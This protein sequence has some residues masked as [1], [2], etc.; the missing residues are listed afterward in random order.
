MLANA[1]SLAKYFNEK[2][3]KLSTGGTDNHILLIDLKNK[4]VS[5][6][7][8]EFLAE[9]VDISLNK[10]SVYGDK[11]AANPSGIRIGTAAL[12]TR[13][14]NTHDFR[15]VGYFVDS[16]V[17]MCQCIQEK[18]GKKLIDFKNFC[19]NDEDTKEKIQ[20]LKDEVN[21][22]AETFPFIESIVV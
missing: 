19:K 14:M 22:F 13:E 3:Y 4:G 12:T 17:K 11:S 2:K 15:R 7:K 8:V 20:K 1:K 18:S 10:N 9:C 6:A 21:V 5:G 16:V